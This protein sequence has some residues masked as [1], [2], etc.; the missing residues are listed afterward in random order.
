MS[1]KQ[2]IPKPMMTVL[3][4]GYTLYAKC[5]KSLKIKKCLI[6]A[7]LNP[8]KAVC[9]CPCCDNRLRSFESGYFTRMPNVYNPKRYKG[10]KQEVVC[11][12]CGAIPRHRI[13]ATYF[14]KHKGELK[15]KRI[16]YFACE[17]GLWTWMKRNRISITTAD[18]FATANLKLDLC[19]IVQPDNSWDWI[20][21]NHVLEHVDEYKQAL[22]ELYRIL[23]PG[24]KL[25]ISFPILA[26]LQ[27]I[28]EETEHTEKNKKKRLELY[29]QA[30]HLRI[31]GADSKDVLIQ[32]GFNVDIID[33][34]RMDKRI[35]PVVGPADYDV[36]YLFLC[37][38]QKGG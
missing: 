17:S 11:P 27:T 25:I 29:G 12:I 14:N 30:D 28:I 38:K 24:G 34:S 5:K 2:H 37:K 31:F 6:D 26:S 13:L 32:A 10:I 35:M 9:Y 8:S 23:K 21:C 1:I 16:L 22:N 15:N 18:F 33:G 36:N 3:L 19:N 4:K 7:K 20:I